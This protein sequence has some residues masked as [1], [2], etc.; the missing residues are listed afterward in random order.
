MTYLEEKDG[1]DRRK[2]TPRLKRL[3]KIP[4]ESVKFLA[5]TARFAPVEKMIEI[6]TSAAYSTLWLSLTGTL[7]FHG[8]TFVVL[9]FVTGS[10]YFVI[11]I[12]AWIP[13]TTPQVLLFAACV[14]VLLLDMDDVK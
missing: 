11:Q 14:T 1:Q 5:P 8:L 7:Y 4:P 10:F 2:S 13:G 6:G 12:W 3:R 9:L